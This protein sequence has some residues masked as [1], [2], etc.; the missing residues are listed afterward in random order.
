MEALNELEEMVDSGEVED[1]PVKRLERFVGD[2][3]GTYK[4]TAIAVRILRKLYELEEGKNITEYSVGAI[5]SRI[6]GSTDRDMVSELMDL[7]PIIIESESFADLGVSGSPEKRTG[8]S[9]QAN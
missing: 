1:V 7:L 6:L 4:A 3:L 9:E 2:E 5:H 8:Y